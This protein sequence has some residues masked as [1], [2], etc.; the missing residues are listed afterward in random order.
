MT[1]RRSREVPP[2]PTSIRTRYRI[3]QGLDQVRRGIDGG[4]YLSRPRGWVG[5]LL[6]GHPGSRDVGKQ[7]CVRRVQLR[8]DRNSANCGTTWSIRLEWNAC[9]VRT[10]RAR[11]RV[12]AGCAAAR[13]CSPATRRP[14]SFRDR[15]PRQDRRPGGECSARSSG[16]IAT[17]TIAPGGESCISRARTATTRIA[18]SRSNTPASVAAAYSPM[19]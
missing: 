16:L 6:G 10:R 5:R 8:R 11:S 17:A 1:N 9:D 12:D 19:P 14:R 15:S 18:V 7:R 4:A 13:G 3:A 2:G